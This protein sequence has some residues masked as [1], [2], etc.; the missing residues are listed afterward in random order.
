MIHPFVSVWVEKEDPGEEEKK[1]AERRSRDK[2]TEGH[3]SS[4]G[5]SLRGPKARSSSVT[6]GGMG[7]KAGQQRS[8]E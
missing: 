7:V 6:G 4:L 8:G 1:S 2:G 3:I 5:T